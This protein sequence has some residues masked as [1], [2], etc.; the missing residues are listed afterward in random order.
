M[1]GRVRWLVRAIAIIPV[2]IAVLALVGL[3]VMLLWNSLVPELFHGPLLGYWQ[4]LGM[5]VLSRLLFGGLR[6]RG[7]HGHWRQRLWR[8]RWE[9][10]T[11]EERARVR[12]HFQRRCGHYGP[13]EAA[14]ATPSPSS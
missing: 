11:P 4:A 14:P 13:H 5:L 6:G 3:V 7:W 8:E 9:Q 12:E 2:V 10:M 1:K